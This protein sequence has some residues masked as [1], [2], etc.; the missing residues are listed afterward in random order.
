MKSE[1]GSQ[2]RP[3]GRRRRERRKQRRKKRRKK[4]R[5]GKKAT[6]GDVRGKTPTLLRRQKNEKKNP[7]I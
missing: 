7:E 5:K 6:P 3:R 2:G 4:R 1:S